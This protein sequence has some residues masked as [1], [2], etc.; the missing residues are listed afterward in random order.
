MPSKP[1]LLIGL[2]HWLND[3]RAEEFK[4]K[5][6]EELPQYRVIVMCGVTAIQI[7]EDGK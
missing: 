3:E 2:L 7:L 4:K 1:V 6:E 5:L